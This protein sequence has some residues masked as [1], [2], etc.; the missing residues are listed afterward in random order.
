MVTNLNVNELLFSG[1][2]FLPIS[3]ILPIFYII[4]LITLV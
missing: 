3:P 2:L 1:K 4:A